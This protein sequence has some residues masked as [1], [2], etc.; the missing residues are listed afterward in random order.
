MSYSFFDFHVP[1]CFEI[2]FSD[3][4]SGNQ[5]PAYPFFSVDGPNVIIPSAPLPSPAESQTVT[6]FLITVFNKF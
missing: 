4:A 1:E 5:I 6:S 3:F 2:H